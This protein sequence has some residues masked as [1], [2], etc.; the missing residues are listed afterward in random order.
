MLTTQ[1]SK[2]NIQPSEMRPGLQHGDRELGD[3]GLGGADVRGFYAAL[4]IRLPGWA[5]TNATVRCFACPD[6]HAHGDRSPSCSVSLQHGAWRCWACGAHGGAYDAALAR[7]HTP[8][9]AM[10]LIRRHG[11]AQSRNPRA[12]APAAPKPVR[13]AAAAGVPHPLGASDADVAAWHE[14]LLSSESQRWL[15]LVCRER[16]WEPATIRELEVGFDGAR[17]TIPIRNAAGDLRGVL[18]Y[19]PGGRTHKMLAVAGTRL[20]LIPHPARERSRRIMLVEGPPDMI[21]ARSG[22][23]PAIAVPGDHAWQPH[24][25]RLLADREVI[26]VTDSDAPGRAAA[27]RIAA[28]LEPVAAV[29]VVDLAPGREDGYDLTNWLREQPRRRRV[30]CARSSSPTATIKR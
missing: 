3:S 15:G 27:R 22:G 9:S 5:Q 21:A 10:D 26:V 18:R 30:P 7:G 16:L 1:M 24:W 2:H 4:G 17:I 23:W 19:L 29:R 25:A 6:A 12:A 14:R 8:A 20:G 28:D 13:S 11:L